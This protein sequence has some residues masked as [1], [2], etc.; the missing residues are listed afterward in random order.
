MLT[1]GEVTTVNVSNPAQGTWTLRLDAAA[2]VPLQ[3]YHLE[4]FGQESDL[5]IDADVEEFVWSTGG[6][7]AH[8]LLELLPDAWRSSWV[9]R[10]V[11][12]LPGLR[13]PSSPA[14]RAATISNMQAST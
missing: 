2:G 9:S 14:S 1:D 6:Q 10:P 11:Q 3:P 12:L 13:L 7:P 4:V 5:S 8:A